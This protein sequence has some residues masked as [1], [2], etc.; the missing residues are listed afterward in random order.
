MSSSWF[1]DILDVRPDAPE[2][3]LLG[4]AGSGSVHR[5][6]DILEALERRLRLIQSSKLGPAQVESA[7]EL[8]HW[9]AARLLKQ[10]QAEVD[11]ASATA[12]MAHAPLSHLDREVLLI[13]A[14]N[15]GWNRRSRTRLEFIAQREGISPEGLGRIIT[16]LSRMAA[17]GGFSTLSEQQV[18]E[19]QAMPILSRPRK[20]SRLTQ[21]ADQV[22]SKLAEEIRAETPGKFFRVAAL[23]MLLGIFIIVIFT[24]LLF[25]KREQDHVPPVDWQQE[26]SAP[27]D[28][29]E[30]TVMPV[31]PDEGMAPEILPAKYARPPMFSAEPYPESSVQASQ[32]LA[33]VLADLKSM[34]RK[35]SL[36]PERFSD[37]MIE[38]W[39]I[40]LLDSSL[41]WPLAG[42]RQQDAVLDAITA[43]I[44]PISLEDQASILLEPLAM[45]PVQVMTQS[46]LLRAIFGAGVLAELSGNNDMSPAVKIT[47]NRLLKQIGLDPSAI[48][49]SDRFGSSVRAWLI[50]A[51]PELL[52]RLASDDQALMNWETW[53]HVHEDVVDEEL[54]DLDRA[55]V[56]GALLGS[57]YNLSRDHPATDL[58]GR[59]LNEISFDGT[60]SS[61][62]TLRDEVATLFD[63]DDLSGGAL[64]VLSSL[65]A[66]SAEASW[67]TQ[68]MILPDDASMQQRQELAMLVQQ[69]WPDVVELP[70]LRTGIEVDPWMYR[71]WRDALDVIDATNPALGQLDAKM[72]QLLRLSRVVEAARYMQHDEDELADEV[73]FELETDLMLPVGTDLL[74]RPVS[75][76]HQVGRV[77]GTDGEWALQFEIAADEGDMDQMEYLL[78]QLMNFSSGDLG[79]QDAQVLVEIAYR[80]REQ[81][82]SLAQSAILLQFQGGQNVAMALLNGWKSAR[83]TVV[84][85]DFIRELTGESLPPH[86][87]SDYEDK[88]RLALVR[89]ALSLYPS[90]HHVIDNLAL[91]LRQSLL[92][93]LGSL[94]DGTMPAGAGSTLLDAIK[95]VVDR[96]RANAGRLFFVEPFP[97]PLEQMDQDRMVRSGLAEGIV[98]SLVAEQASLIDL[99]AYSLVANQPQLRDV[100]MELLETAAADRADCIDV[101][102][103]ACINEQT[104]AR[105][106]GLSFQVDE[107]AGSAGGDQ[108]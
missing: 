99:E 31:I 76:T 37:A 68:Q 11:T 6:R 64:W 34:A 25:D 8:M 88:A 59:L 12:P 82:Q 27:I 3:Q 89:H 40:D 70:D 58:L 97:A 91:Q 39:R 33:V 23:F 26:A 96:S 100:V 21:L 1:M 108:S 92:N 61:G 101:L 80:G 93:R 18:P 2:E 29:G 67:F 77:Q 47:C 74:D 73:L 30:A 60:S 53:L 65:L 13:L 63:D 46:E 94:S 84:T 5:P 106:M 36:R 42:T 4:L 103:Q 41:A 24:Q 102:E 78:K 32:R 66:E 72:H 54:L 56:V 62:Q 69:A 19:L 45:A 38:N 87:D 83:R 52:S 20:P 16:G 55:R 17:Q 85:G 57:S 79:P 107:D 81:L 98:Q 22:N 50:G 95:A 75:S 28:R 49:A 86:R 105:L 90:S 104:I 43:V 15:G 48:T 7:S 51:V 10:Y 9:A 44:Q 35:T 14:T 71:R